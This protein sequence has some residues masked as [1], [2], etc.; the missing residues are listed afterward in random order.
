MKKTT[1]RLCAALVT[2]ICALSTIGAASVSAITINTPV[3]QS[4]MRQDWVGHVYAN[5]AFNIFKVHYPDRS[6]WVGGDP[7]SCLT[8]NPQNKPSNHFMID[9]VLTDGFYQATINYDCTKSKGFALNCAAEFFATKSFMQIGS[10]HDQNGHYNPRPGDV[11]Y[12]SDTNTW[13]YV[14][15]ESGGTYDYAECNNTTCQVRWKTMT[16]AQLIS[17]GSSVMRPMMEGDINGDSY[18]DQT[19]LSYIQ[20]YIMHVRNGLPFNY[21]NNFWKGAA[22]IDKNGTV[23]LA[24][25]LKLSLALQNGNNMYYLKRQA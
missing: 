3:V 22:D 13:I 20:D 16:E 25:S 8:T 23:D 19:D 2:A 24:D 21:N 11:T 18:V 5:Q 15:K 14:C 9:D 10:Y 12:L 1:K 4:P 17:R 6:Y 7:R